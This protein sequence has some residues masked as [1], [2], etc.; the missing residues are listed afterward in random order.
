MGE[1]GEVE[2]GE[3]GPEQEGLESEDRHGGWI[4]RGEFA[5][6]ESRRFRFKG[7]GVMSGDGWIVTE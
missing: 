2:G 3:E 4:C 6:G 7:A 1:G 5:G